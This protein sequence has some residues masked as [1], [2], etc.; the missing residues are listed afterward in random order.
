M[1]PVYREIGDWL[2][3]CDNT[4][5]CVARYV[6]E[7]D[8]ALQGDDNGDVFGM[9]IVREEGPIGLQIG[10]SGIGSLR[11]DAMLVDGRAAPRVAWVGS[12]DRDGAKAVDD[13]ALRFLRGI[14][15]AHE[16]TV[17]AKTRRQSVSL[18]GLTAVLLA[19]DEVQ[20]RLGNRSAIVRVGPKPSGA[21]PRV[22]PLPVITVRRSSAM[23]GGAVF[24]AAVRRGQ[25]ALLKAHECDM[26]PGIGD[27]ADLLPNGKA[28]VVIG[29]GR[30]AYQTSSLAFVG[31][32]GNPRSAR[33]LVLPQP[34]IIDQPSEPNTA[35]EYVELVF[36][37]ARSTL[38]EFSKGRGMADC[39]SRTEWAFDGATFR[40]ATFEWQQRCGGDRDMWLALYRTELKTTD[41]TR[42]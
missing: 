11:A 42:G 31:D 5:R 22:V 13:A 24:A 21:T 38:A 33:L 20:G 40:L 39:G 28:L 25:S 6:P 2:L 10:L 8:G 19:I 34:P 3:G 23:P 32:P 4:R 15:A 1:L 37:P 12:A 7:E 14:A 17:P 16:L 41:R 30:F 9:T 36:D 18:K 26:D 27:G 35:G 29:C